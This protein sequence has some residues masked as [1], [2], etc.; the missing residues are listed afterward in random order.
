MAESIDRRAAERMAVNATTGCGFVGPVTE[1]FGPGKVRDVSLDG[2]GLLL[3]RRVEIG[4][5]LAVTITNSAQ[6]V[7][8]TVLV[9]VAHV[10]V[11]HG[12]FLVAGTFLE[13]LT[14]QEFTG[15]VM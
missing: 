1:G 7:S 11:A 9:R 3:T 8:K 13:P 10:T 12:G 4:A 2:V 15:L 6:K 14:Y 5:L